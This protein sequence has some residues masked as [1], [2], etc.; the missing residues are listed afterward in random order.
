MKSTSGNLEDLKKLETNILDKTMSKVEDTIL[1]KIEEK[2]QK[3]R[4]YQSEAFTSH[5]METGNDINNLA[6]AFEK[7]LEDQNLK[8]LKFET[9]LEELN[10]QFGD[11][12]QKSQLKTVYK[13]VES[14]KTECKTESESLRKDIENMV[15]ELQRLDTKTG[16]ENKLIETH[17]E[18]S[19]GTLKTQFQES[20]GSRDEKI[21]DLE[22]SLGNMKTEQNKT[23][24]DFLED[25]DSKLD[26]LQKSLGNFQQQINDEQESKLKS[27]KSSFGT[28]KQE[29]Q[30]QQD[31]KMKKLESSIGSIDGLNQGLSELSQNSE[32]KYQDLKGKIENLAASKDTEMMVKQ[33]IKKLELE[34]SSVKTS[35][36]SQIQALEGKVQKLEKTEKPED[37]IEKLKVEHQEK[38]KNLENKL[39]NKLESFRKTMMNP[40]THPNAANDKDTNEKLR[41]L[42]LNLE[43]KL[44][45]FKKELVK[46][47]NSKEM[48]DNVKNL[49][50]CLD[51][52]LESLK[53][54]VSRCESKYAKIEILNDFD[55]TVIKK[56]D[57]KIATIDKSLNDKLSELKDQAIK[58]GQILKVSLETELDAKVGS[59][60]QTA[61]NDIFEHID[62]KVNDLSKFQADIQA[63]L[64]GKA[65]K[66]DLL[67]WTGQVKSCTQNWTLVKDEVR[68]LTSKL[69]DKEDH[70]H[71]T[72]NGLSENVT[73]TVKK[74]EEIEA[75]ALTSI[76][77]FTHDLHEQQKS[78][79]EQQMERKM[80]LE[81]LNL[82]IETNAR[83]CYD[84]NKATK[85]NGKMAT[86]QLQHYDRFSDKL[87]KIENHLDVVHKELAKSIH[88][89]DKH[90]DEIDDLSMKL[91]NTTAVNET[92]EVLADLQDNFKTIQVHIASL[93]DNY[94]KVESLEQQMKAITESKNNGEI[95]PLKLVSLRKKSATPPSPRPRDKSPAIFRSEIDELKSVAADNQTGTP[96][97]I[98]S[99]QSSKLSV[100]SEDFPQ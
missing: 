94:D 23:V 35:S 83:M 46:I 74:M 28:F 84:I 95:S 3:M 49:E 58:D 12:S 56:L 43:G 5:C 60:V 90:S 33:E 52:K 68:K 36:Q 30:E 8:L 53:T 24:Q 71:K 100:V 21:Q 76:K 42:Q 65:D 34:L 48:S 16:Q 61:K 44:D 26:H 32:Q 96:T 64:Q 11:F 38:V 70:D 19:I 6:A 82:E 25:Q 85:E 99:D 41:L 7:Q 29:I 57:D 66:D 27:I 69:K 10:E 45:N 91:K 22:K 89:I 79:K 14:L 13:E 15:Q 87:L 55:M 97:M 86:Q 47:Q 67:K 51:S 17:L 31:L 62:N 37:N 73:K 75:K 92:D 93:R 2:L 59:E 81:Q 50:Q 63:H 20:L 54:S 88:I 40:D 80:E 1:D 98:I 39:E 78:L 4:E 18:Q 77:N 9:I 72:L